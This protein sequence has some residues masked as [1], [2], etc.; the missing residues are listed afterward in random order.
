[1]DWPPAKDIIE[2][3]EGYEALDGFP[4]VY[5][6]VAGDDIGQLLDSRSPEGCPSFSGF[7]SRSSEELLQ[8]LELALQNQKQIL[9]GKWGSGTAEEARIAEEVKWLKTV[10]CTPPISWLI[11]LVF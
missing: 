11:H 2:P 1:M 4:G 7:L 5:I 3:P 6:C 9:V 8:L 10:R